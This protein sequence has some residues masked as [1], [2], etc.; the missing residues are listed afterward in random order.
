MTLAVLASPDAGAQAQDVGTVMAASP[1]ATPAAVV[2][3]TPA[4]TS[5]PVATEAAAAPAAT[6]AAP[7]ATEAATQ[8]P[9][10]ATESAAPVAT[11]APTTATP[12]AVPTA[13]EAA[14]TVAAATSAPTSAG[15]S[16]TS[17]P[18]AAPPTPTS[19]AA[20]DTSATVLQDTTPSQSGVR[21][22]DAE[23]SAS[24]LSSASKSTSD[25]TTGTLD[26]SSSS[27]TVVIVVLGGVG[28]AI[29]MS[30]LFV[31][32][33]SQRHEDPDLDTP[34]PPDTA[35]I[36]F[37]AVSMPS[38]VAPTAQDMSTWKARGSSFASR[39]LPLTESTRAK[40]NATTRSSTEY[41]LANRPSQIASLSARG[42]A[43]HMPHDSRDTNAS[44]EQSF[45]IR[46]YSEFSV[47]HAGDSETSAMTSERYSTNGGYSTS[48]RYSTNGRYSTSSR[49]SSEPGGSNSG[50]FQQH[51]V[52]KNLDMHRF[53]STSSTASSVVAR[54]HNPVSFIN[55]D[56]TQTPNAETPVTTHST[57][58]RTDVPDWYSVIESPTDN[59]RYTASSLDSDNISDERESFEL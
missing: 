51:Q 4:E 33:R 18:T 21:G 19:Q 34:I 46:G 39:D 40:L 8:A 12:A 10:A 22:S 17:I 36:T 42:T 25:T 41:D 37:P 50:W 47:R 16:T 6:T 28:A 2:T 32:W 23:S 44:S 53:S 14:A 5:A 13:T 59:D 30:L 56:L 24:S 45:S 20:P 35:T 15:T 48:D 27:K 3:E 57:T 1:E 31:L 7:V 52:P 49:L 43:T 11:E 9:P 54:R 29:I 38:I 26:G 55:H 58:S